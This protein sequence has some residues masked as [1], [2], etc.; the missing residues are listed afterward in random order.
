MSTNK[1][2]YQGP[3]SAGDKEL[4]RQDRVDKGYDEKPKKPP[5]QIDG[6]MSIT[7]AMQEENNDK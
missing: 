2:G 1:S 7:K 6:Q 3:D 5:K 4:K